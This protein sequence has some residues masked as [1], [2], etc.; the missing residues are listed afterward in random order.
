MKVAELVQILL[1]MDQGSEV[2]TP[3]G[4]M[5][6]YLDLEPSDIKPCHLQPCEGFT[7]IYT[8]SSENYPG[9]FRAVILG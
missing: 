6:D 9:S 8:R 1:K 2:C 5:P 7:D 4:E 3:N